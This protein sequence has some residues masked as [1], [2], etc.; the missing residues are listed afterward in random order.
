VSQLNKMVIL[1]PAFQIKPSSFSFL[2]LY[3]ID[4]LLL[5]FNL[6][7]FFS[8][9]FPTKHTRSKTRKFGRFL[10]K[11]PTCQAAS[12]FPA[13]Y[14]CQLPAASQLPT[15]ASC[16]DAIF[17]AN[18]A[19]RIYHM[20]RCRCR[21]GCTTTNVLSSLLT[22]SMGYRSICFCSLAYLSISRLHCILFTV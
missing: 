15:A 7:L 6:F 20:H 18:T 8:L 3:S 22:S 14:S 10:S 16:Q 9:S 17:D 19:R 12:S 13:A 1:A 5:H 21:P 11:L 4:N 2:S